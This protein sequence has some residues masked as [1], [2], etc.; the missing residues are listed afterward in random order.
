MSGPLQSV[1]R[2][3]D[4][5]PGRILLLITGAVVLLLGAIM[6]VSL[7]LVVV[8]VLRNPADVALIALVM[9]SMQEGGVAL[10]GHL[11]EFEFALR[12]EEPLRTL[13]FLV[14]CV[15]LLGALASILKTI[16]LT[17]KAL[18]ERGRGSAAD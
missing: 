13:L 6:L 1:S 18:L 3:T 16:V 8:D 17:G 11:G 9:Q 15:W 2:R 14:V 10:T 12:I 4:S 5:D 7:A